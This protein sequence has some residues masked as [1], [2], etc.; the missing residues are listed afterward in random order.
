MRN[1]IVPKSEPAVVEGHL[2]MGDS[3]THPDAIGVNSRFVTRRGL[4][5]LPVAGEF[6]FS[7][8]PAV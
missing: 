2:R 1:L 6:H 7:R 3:P 4:P 8:Y 5:W